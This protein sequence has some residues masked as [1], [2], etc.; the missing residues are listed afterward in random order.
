MT[1]NGDGY[2]GWA[3]VEVLVEDLGLELGLSG[4]GY[5]LNVGRADKQRGVTQSDCHVETA[6]IL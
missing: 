4:V 3:Q 5:C 6:H 1:E 2:N